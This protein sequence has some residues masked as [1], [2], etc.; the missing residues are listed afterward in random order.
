M[1][2]SE[3]LRIDERFYVLT[4]VDAMPLSGMIYH[5]NERAIN[6]YHISV[7]G[8]IKFIAHNAHS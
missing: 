7:N 4:H 3:K 5:S 6:K 2:A 8:S 1:G